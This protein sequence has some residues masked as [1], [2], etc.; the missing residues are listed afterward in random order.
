[1]LRRN[2]AVPPTA[3]IGFLPARL[4]HDA[5][6]RILQ[7]TKAAVLLD[8]VNGYLRSRELV[9]VTL[10]AAAKPA[11]LPD[12]Y[13]GTLEAE[14]MVP[15]YMRPECPP[16]Q[17]KCVLLAGFSGQG[18]TLAGLREQMRTQ[19]LQYLLVPI[20]RESYIYPSARV[21]TAGP[22]STSGATARSYYFDLGS[23]YAVERTALR[24]LD[25]PEPVLTLTGALLDADGK[26]VI[27]GAEGFKIAAEGAKGFLRREAFEFTAEDYEAALTTDRRQDL[28][29]AA[30]NWKVAAKYLY[31]TLT[32]RQ[33]PATAGP[34][35][36]LSGR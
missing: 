33:P 12:V 14:T 10:P 17:Q 36:M 34:Y 5:A 25:A 11:W 4:Q 28:P 23:G 19:N 20:L 3:R 7:K 16:D 9:P 35:R 26:L 18:K 6:E 2:A 21:S 13:F 15:P 29:A 24:P 27:I 22:V 31:Q 8:S 30:P 32:M 1:M